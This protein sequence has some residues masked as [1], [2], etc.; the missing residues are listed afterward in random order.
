MDTLSIPFRFSNG[1][2][3]TH[4]QGS[5]SYYMHILSNVLQSEPGEIALDTEFGTNDPVF[6]RV[7]RASIVEMA[8]KYVPEIRIDKV[9]SIIDD[10]GIEK[11]VISYVV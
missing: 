5:D 10:D 3:V 8:A 2:A 9:V 6:E 4:A 11:I 7:N 1:S